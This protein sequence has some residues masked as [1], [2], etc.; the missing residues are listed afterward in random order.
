MFQKPLKIDQTEYHE[1]IQTM[2]KVSLP[3]LIIF[4]LCRS[5][6][7]QETITPQP[8]KSI[9]HHY[10]VFNAQSV[11]YAAIAEETF[12]YGKN[13][14]IPD[15]SIITFSYIKD[16]TGGN[17]KRPVIFIFNGG[18]GASSSPLHLHAFGPYIFPAEVGRSLVD[19][20]NSLLDVADLVF[21]DPVGTGYT[22]LFDEKAASA[23]WDVKEDARSILFVIKAWKQKYSRESSP[24]FICGESY[25]TLR[26]AEMIGIN[27]DLQV[28]GIIMLSAILDL[29]SPTAVPG[30]D[31]PYVVNLPSLSAI[32]YYHGKASVNANNA[33]EMF[34]KACVFA[35]NQYFKALVKGNRLSEKEKKNIAQKLSGYIGL[36]VD[37]I[38]ARDL[39]IKPENFQLLLLADQ[40]KR[41]GLLNGCKTG[42][43]HTDLKPPYSD[44]SMGMTK[45][46]VSAILIKQY[47]NSTLNFQDTG[48]YKSLNLDINSKWIWSSAL[49]DFYY[50][51]VPEFSKAVI[52]DHGLKIFIAGG[53]FDM[54]TPFYAAKY[55]F[56]HSGISSDRMVF[57]SFPTGHSIFEDQNELKILAD[58][59]RQFIL[60]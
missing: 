47:F 25:G 56:E 46:T 35:E 17:E 43:L 53:I 34:E 1:K 22:R 27:K 11:N 30:N 7:G 40:D 19:N 59:I 23:Y 38:L 60:K 29:S 10:G 37:T 33:S 54:A 36:P 14:K 32:A 41:I 42:P 49:K 21:I 8:W 13:E 2:K 5:L 50:T 51:V 39:R 58:K 44:P 12:L 4:L 9:T 52:K 31:I 28:S 16:K 24:L 57:E 26:L 15:A 18:P 45:D 48:R 20:T 6:Y 55:Q 3:V